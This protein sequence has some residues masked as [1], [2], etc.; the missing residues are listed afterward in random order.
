[1]RGGWLYFSA[2]PENATQKYLFR[3]RLS[4]DG[5]AERLSPANQPGTHN[6]NIAPRGELAIHT[7]STFNKPADHRD[8]PPIATHQ[9]ADVD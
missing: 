2:S 7:Y 5:K 6:Y 9:R 4:G 8:R 3:V 1:V